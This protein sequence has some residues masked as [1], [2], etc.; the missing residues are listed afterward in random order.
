MCRLAPKTVCPKQRVSV[1][2]LR[3][4][5]RLIVAVMILLVLTG[6]ALSVASIVLRRQ[7]EAI[8]RAVQELS[9]QPHAATIAD[10]K[11]LLGSRIKLTRCVSASDC[12]Y[13]V[14]VSNRVLAWFRLVPYSEIRTYFWTRDGVVVGSMTDFTVNPHRRRAIV[15]H[16][17]I[18]YCDECQS[19]SIH[20]WGH[21]SE[22]GT[23]GLVEI[24]NQASAKNKQTALSLRTDCLIKL[25]GCDTIADLLPTVW[26]VEGGRIA[27]TVQNDRGLVV[28]PAG[29]R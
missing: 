19:F 13:E 3:M 22:L 2:K 20:P 11:Q 21:S 27:C 18:D 15:T 1:S 4:F 5:C 26:N 9:A 10:A 29:W 6:C 17:Q 23:N 7:A 12:E 8:V 28:K 14:V 16:V 24:G 25:G